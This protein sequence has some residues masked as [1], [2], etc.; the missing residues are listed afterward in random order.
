MGT[1]NLTG[2]AGNIGYQN[3][4]NSF[5]INEDDNDGIDTQ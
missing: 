2:F 3:F 5:M 1:T 4:G